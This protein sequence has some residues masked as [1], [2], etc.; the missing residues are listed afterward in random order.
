MRLRK[1]L[2]VTVLKQAE[3]K[4]H[5]LLVVLFGNPFIDAVESKKKK[6]KHFGIKE[7]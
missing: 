6:K 3:V 7:W 2:T 1:L 5:K 4:H